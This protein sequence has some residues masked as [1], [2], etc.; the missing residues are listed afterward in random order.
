MHTETIFAA[1][2]GIIVVSYALAH[3]R[4]NRVIACEKVVL[5]VFPKM[6]P[7][8]HE[9]EDIVDKVREKRPGSSKNDV[10]MALYRL[11]SLGYADVDVHEEWFYVPQG[12]A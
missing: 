5:R 2:A 6:A 11:R 12:V 3:Y 4:S 10:R 8:A 9:L 7:W 1:V